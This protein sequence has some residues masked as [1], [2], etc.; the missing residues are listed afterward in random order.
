[1]TDTPPGFTIEYQG[2]VAV[3][4]PNGP[5]AAAWL[6]ATADADARFVG[7][8]LAIE[9]R[10]VSDT[11]DA[12]RAAGFAVTIGGRSYPPTEGPKSPPD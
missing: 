3:V 7:D 11:I 9:P 8:A 10:L 4:Y 2:T 1:M 6:Q 12:M 5:E